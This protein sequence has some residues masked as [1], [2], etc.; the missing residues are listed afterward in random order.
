MPAI[1]SDWFSRKRAPTTVDAKTA[2]RRLIRMLSADA[3]RRARPPITL[4]GPRAGNGADS[5]RPADDRANGRAAIA[6]SPPAP[7]PKW[8]A[9]APRGHGSQSGMK[10]GAKPTRADKKGPYSRAE[11]RRMDQ[12]FK[13]AVERAIKNGGEHRQSAAM[14]GANASRPR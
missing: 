9:Y 7:R 6:A 10:N 14:N 13:A 2:R 8:Q 12:R 11:L 3:E 5:D 4:A 1:H